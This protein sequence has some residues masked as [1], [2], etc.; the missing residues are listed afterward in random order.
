MLTR[1]ILKHIRNNY[2]CRS[3]TSLRWNERWQP[4]AAHVSVG[5]TPSSPTLSMN[6]WQPSTIF[7]PP[8]SAT[9]LWHSKKDTTTALVLTHSSSSRL[10]L[11]FNRLVFVHFVF[12]FFMVVCYIKR[13]IKWLSVK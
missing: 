9:F 2:G 6:S 10:P 13:K 7:P 5:V 12:V 11:E 1:R 4:H 3:V 8:A